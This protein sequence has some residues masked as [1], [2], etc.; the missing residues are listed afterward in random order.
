MEWV[1]LAPALVTAEACSKSWSLPHHTWAA[2]QI[3]VCGSLT[4]AKAWERLKLTEADGCPASRCTFVFYN[5]SPILCQAL[6]IDCIL[7]SCLI[8]HGFITI[9]SRHCERSPGSCKR[10]KVRWG[11]G[12][13]L[14]GPVIWTS[15][16]ASYNTQFSTV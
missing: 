3:L 15:P 13:E 11:Q 14:S 9:S 8:C 16:T 4:L 5:V 1:S 12:A 10:I 2:W 7:K 6:K